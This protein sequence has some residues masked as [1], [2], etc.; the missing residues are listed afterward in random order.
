MTEQ[1]AT[2]AG[3]MPYRPEIDGL[4][5]IAVLSVVLYHFGVPGLGGGFVGVDIF[6]VISGYLI[7]GILWGE[8]AR[9]GRV[10]LIRFYIRRFR[11]LAPAFFA[12]AAAVALVGWVVLLP[13]EYRE[14]SKS[15]IAATVYLANVQF[16][17]QA[18]YFDTGADE[19]VLLHT[20]SLSVEEQFYVVLPL[21]ILLLRR[22][23]G[24]LHLLLWAAFAVSLGASLTLSTRM[25]EA[26]FY[27][28]HFRAWELLAGVLLAIAHFQGRRLPDGAQG[29]GSA[30]G[31]VLLAGSVAL[32]QPGPGFPGVQAVFPVLGTVLILAGAGQANAVN[33]VLALRGPVFVGLISYS[34]Y[35]WHWPVFS[36]ST[37][38]RGAYAGPLEV[39]GW[40]GLSL[41][42][43]MISWRFVEQPFR[44][45]YL[46]QEE[47]A[48]RVFGGVALASGLT[49]A[50]GALIFVKDGLPQRFDAVARGH[51][52][53]TG[54]FLQD[55]SRC[56]YEAAGPL[57]GVE[58]CRIGPDGAP[59][60][61]VWGDSHLRAMM[62][63]IGLAALEAD[64]PGMLI[65]TAG[66]P[67]LFGV[68][69]EES[70]STAAENRAC[71]EINARIEA[72]L[73]SLDSVE[74]VLVVARWSY[75]AE[76]QGHGLDAQNRISLAPAPGAGL[77]G[78][79]DLMAA[80]MARTMG[81]LSQL[82]PVHV[83][84]Q[85]PEMPDYTSSRAARALAYGRG[86]AVAPTLSVPRAAA[87]ARGARADAMLRDLAAGG[88]ITLIDPWPRLCDAQACGVMLEGAPV[89]F[90]TNHLTNRGA[91]LL[92]DLL[93]PALA[94]GDG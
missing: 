75:Y 66:C 41:V 70:A 2:G 50:F 54:D 60:V 45:G 10:S 7:G 15:L 72:A 37:T 73:P 55:W 57:E 63:G 83:L 93:M 82:G 78:A 12:M 46:K 90:D 9:T 27:L 80:A 52:A 6:F 59:R 74:R 25:P 16:W 56:A 51:I 94:G 38:W 28:F 86:E 22:H 21:L 64:V 29:I 19:K 42:L 67:P 43:A 92:R 87:E 81:A 17:R 14:F 58:V 88:A 85:V 76:G 53:A 69:K 35:L 11:R 39:A 23:A 26:A 18:G 40:I 68:T 62:D 3:R 33:R 61:L 91:L 13:A 44:R 84:R 71:P 89:Y 20:W 8:H 36:L 48:P 32:I 47:A 5:S 34:L 79:P 24:A 30:L 31:I 1:Q 77:E 65:W 4:R 49:L